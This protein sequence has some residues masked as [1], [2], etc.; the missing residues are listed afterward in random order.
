[1]CVYPEIY[2]IFRF[3]AKVSL[4]HLKTTFTFHVLISERYWLEDSPLIFIYLRVL[5]R[6]PSH[7]GQ[8]ASAKPS[9]NEQV[10]GRVD[11]DLVDL[12]V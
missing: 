11:W 12:L 3:I 6:P 7:G 5:L 1:M 4:N 10:G 2:Y 8:I 9:W